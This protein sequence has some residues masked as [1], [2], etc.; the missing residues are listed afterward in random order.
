MSLPGARKFERII[1]VLD[2]VGHKINTNGFAEIRLGK[3]ESVNIYTRLKL[4]RTGINGLTPRL[5]A[6]DFL[7]YFISNQHVK[8]APINMFTYLASAFL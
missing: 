7:G 1:Q 5:V 3:H 4:I 6:K 8:R 2:S